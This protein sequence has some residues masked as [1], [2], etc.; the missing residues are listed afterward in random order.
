MNRGLINF[1]IVFFVV[2]VSLFLLQQGRIPNQPNYF[3]FF[4]TL[5]IV[6][7]AVV[8]LVIYVKKNQG[9]QAPELIATNIRKLFNAIKNNNRDDAYFSYLRIASKF[10]KKFG[11]WNIGAEGFGT[12]YG[13]FKINGIVVY[14]VD[15]VKLRQEFLDILN[16]YKTFE[17]NERILSIEQIDQMFKELTS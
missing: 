6:F 16:Q 5:L 13:I 2:F 17:A 10:G 1:F 4:L 12:P 15:W 3:G 11:F 9:N 7:L 14:S 8:C